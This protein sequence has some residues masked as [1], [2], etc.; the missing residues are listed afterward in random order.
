M[1]GLKHMRLTQ[2]DKIVLNE[3]W[4]KVNLL[5]LNSERELVCT[6][7]KY[8]LVIRAKRAILLRNANVSRGQKSPHVPDFDFQEKDF[9]SAKQDI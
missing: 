5:C 1:L 6:H 7:C 9:S 4:R 3:Q 2:K 8:I